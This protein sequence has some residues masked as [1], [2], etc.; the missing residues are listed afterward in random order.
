MF[1]VCVLFNLFIVYFNGV[2]NISNGA[3]I[4]AELLTLSNQR[5]VPNVFVKGRHVGGNDATQ[6]AIASGELQKALAAK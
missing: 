4:Q 1:C 2:Q 3:E 6:A 5:T